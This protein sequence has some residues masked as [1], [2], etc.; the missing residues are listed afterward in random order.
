[1]PRTRRV[2][3]RP[4]MSLPTYLALQIP[5]AISF[6]SSKCMHWTADGQACIATKTSVYV[7][8]RPFTIVS[9]YVTIKACRLR[10]LVL[11]LIVHQ[12]WKRLLGIRTRMQSRLG[13]FE[14]WLNASRIVH[15]ILAIIGRK[16][17]SVCMRRLLHPA[18]S[19]D[20][21]QSVI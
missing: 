3:R 7:L 1:M 5:S 10:I 19:A 2:Q 16:S 15:W 14:R 11:T 12:C 21:C 13:C 8:V 20:S 6:P 9:I 17:R 18:S 4:S